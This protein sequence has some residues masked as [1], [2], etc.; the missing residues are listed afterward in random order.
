MVIILKDDFE[1]RDF[2]K[3]DNVKTSPTGETARVVT[4]QPHGGLYH[5][6]F[7]CNGDAG[8]EFAFVG[9]S[10]GSR[11][12]LYA[13]AYLKFEDN[14][15][16]TGSE[17]RIQFRGLDQVFEARISDGAVPKWM[18]YYLDGTS[19]KGIQ[20]TTG[21]VIGEYYS[22]ELYGK[23]DSV[24][25]EAT[26]YIDGV[27]VASITGINSAGFG[28][29]TH[30]RVGQ[31]YAV[32]TYV[33]G[34]SVDDV[35]IA[36]TYIGPEPPPP[37]VTYLLAINSIPAPVS[38]L[39]F[40]LDGQSRTTPYSN[41]DETEG[42]HMMVMPANVVVGADIYKFVQWEDDSVDLSRII[43]LI[44]DTTLTATYEL[45]PTPP[46]EQ[47]AL[48]TEGKYIKDK[49][50]NVVQLLGTQK[51][52]YEDDPMGRWAG[53]WGEHNQSVITRNLQAMRSWGI[54]SI[55][56]IERASFWIDNPTVGAMTHREAIKDVIRLANENGIYVVF[57]LFSMDS[58]NGYHGVPWGTT[59][60]PTMQD[61]VDL[62]VSIATELKGYPNV[63]FDL[64]N[65]VV[66]N[67]SEWFEGCRQTISAVRAVT[68]HIIFAHWDWDVWS[69]LL[70]PG[71]GS[72][73][74][75]VTDPKI[76]GTNIVYETH[77]YSDARGFRED[78]SGRT[79]VHT[80]ADIT[81]AFQNELVYQALEQGK[82]LY[83]GEYG[84]FF[85]W[86][87]ELIASENGLKIL[88]DLGVSVNCMWWFTAD[89]Y[90]LLRTHEPDW[91]PTAWGEIVKAIY[92]EV[93][94]PDT[95]P[96]PLSVS[97]KTAGLLLSTLGASGAVVYVVSKSKKEGVK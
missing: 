46:D 4:T 11:K 33:H 81:Q 27:E 14:F 25:G 13:R 56:L 67:Q 63:L 3:W 93:S 40:T 5:A 8:G 61:F 64:W 51:H 85:D 42:S 62:W 84:P 69:N 80:I 34:L 77:M 89:I 47:S 55:R 32:L 48:H 70:N 26:L 60:I 53:A 57:C 65:E 96:P 2:S 71:G 44:E 72:K 21:P 95:P 82:P 38:E 92:S 83:I 22:V 7:R 20:A 76:Q 58:G 90:A 23:V 88:V 19:M 15:P 74:D 54:N 66:Q 50:G 91:I 10:V 59:T 35:V 29:I 28:D 36:D 9:K 12:I 97:W 49:A 1:T 41:P 43:N 52:G 86:S 39:P 78:A 75:W 45:I 18:L 79:Y 68:D 94:P 17:G 6:D 31:L 24:A 37:S 30:V 73:L 87:N 16:N